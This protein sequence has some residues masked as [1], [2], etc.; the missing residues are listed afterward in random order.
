MNESSSTQEQDRP[1][2]SPEDALAVDALLN[3]SAGSAAGNEGVSPERLARADAWLKLLDLSPRPEP[4]GDLS[5]RT[6]DAIQQDRMVLQ[7]AAAM[8]DRAGARPVHGRW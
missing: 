5:Q 1:T 3:K 4:R 7:P 2:L 6:L 8:A